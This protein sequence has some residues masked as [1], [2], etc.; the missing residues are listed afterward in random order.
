MVDPEP[1]VLALSSPPDDVNS[2]HALLEEVWAAHGDVP[3]LDRMAFETA[4]I[5]LASNVIGHADG[6]E[7]ISCSLAV[8]VSEDRI[9]AN[10]VDTGQ[11]GNIVLSAVALPDDLA[12]SGRG[13]P[14]IQALVDE[15][16]YSREDGLN[17][18]HIARKRER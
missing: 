9:E 17:R 2:V 3:D 16:S 13:L 4:L 6:G 18:W 12:E 15:L 5:E 10:L 7:G 1:Q 8:T 14:I 11:P